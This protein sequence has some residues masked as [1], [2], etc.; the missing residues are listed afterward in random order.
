ME[1]RMRKTSEREKALC[2]DNVAVV[3]ARAGYFI[4]Q[5]VCVCVRRGGVNFFKPLTKVVNM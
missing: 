1:F 4:T 2:V 3:K 5:C